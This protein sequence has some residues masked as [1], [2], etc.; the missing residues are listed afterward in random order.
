MKKIEVGAQDL[1]TRDGRD[2]RIYATGMP[3]RFPVHGAINDGDEWNVATWTDEGRC[4]STV[5]RKDMPSDIIL[6]DDSRPK[7]VLWRH[8][9]ACDVR[10]RPEGYTLPADWERVDLKDLAG[11]DE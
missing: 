9:T 4:Y 11:W 2:V 3:G 8:L 1:K 10:L 6:E 7:L 5:I